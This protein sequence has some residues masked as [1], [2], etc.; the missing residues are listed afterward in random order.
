MRFTKTYCVQ[1][2]LWMHQGTMS[3]R[4]SCWHRKWN[5][6]LEKVVLDPGSYF[7]GCGV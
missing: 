4:G 1:A 6:S 2:V 5:L 7:M 3:G